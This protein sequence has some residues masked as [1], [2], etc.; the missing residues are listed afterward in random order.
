M[1]GSGR[2]PFYRGDK[3]DYEQFYDYVIDEKDRLMT[4]DVKEDY[5]L[6]KALAA[7]FELQEYLANRIAEDESIDV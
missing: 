4:L 1:R 6:C 7:C 2:A 3:M 5:H